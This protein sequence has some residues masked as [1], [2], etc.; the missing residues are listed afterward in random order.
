MLRNANGGENSITRIKKKLFS[1]QALCYR[2]QEY[3]QIYQW[4]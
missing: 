4:H 3:G 1:D 2:L